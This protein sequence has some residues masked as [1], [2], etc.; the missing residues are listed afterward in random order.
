VV[1]LTFGLNDEASVVVGL[2][3]R[4]MFTV[5]AVEEGIDPQDARDEWDSDALTEDT[6]VRWQR[7]AMGMVVD[8]LRV[9]VNV[10]PRPTVSEF[11]TLPVLDLDEV[12]RHRDP[13]DENDARSRKHPCQRC[14]S[15]EWSY[16]DYG[17]CSDCRPRE[18]RDD[19]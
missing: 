4:E 1:A 14:G 16:V 12:V 15:E 3:A 9:F 8:A 10:P 2:L 6:Y 5:F 7:A 18:E 13:G 17:G 19:A 11:G